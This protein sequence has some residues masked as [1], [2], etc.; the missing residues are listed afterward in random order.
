MKA[1]RRSL[2]FRLLAGFMSVMF[3]VWLLLG[4]MN[5]YEALTT[6]K[7]AVENDIK[8]VARQS[9]LVMQALATQPG[10]LKRLAAQLEHLENARTALVI[11]TMSPPLHLQVWKD[12]VPVFAS[13]RL[14]AELPQ[15]GAQLVSFSADGA[16]WLASVQADAASGVTVRAAREDPMVA[17]LEPPSIGYFTLPL[18]FSFPFLLLPVWVTIRVGL[19]PV[20]AMS[21]EIERRPVSDLTPLPDS[22][23]KELAPLVDAI[24]RL[25]GRLKERLEREREFL[26][27]AAHELKTPMAVIQVNADTLSEARDAQRVRDAREGL[28]IG[29]E[30]AAHAVHQLLAYARSAAHRDNPSVE[31][32]DLV[33]LLGERIAQYAPLALKRGIEMELQAPERCVLA[34]HRESVFLLID[35]LL[36]NAVKYSPQHGQV[37][38]RVQMQGKAVRLSIIDQGPGIAP[39]LRE[40]VFERF[41]RIPGQD[42][43]GS[44]LG[45]AIAERAA[46]HNHAQVRLD[47]GPDG[48]GLAAIVDFLPPPAA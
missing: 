4:L 39:A 6:G 18:M 22:S 38:V 7:K 37:L 32:L 45:L 33:E 17:L 28:R 34:L 16:K 19:R 29:I 25:M 5:A 36:D 26:A 15:P 24:N 47:Q 27:D 10:E 11:G 3:G 12:G 30:R 20:R 13:T 21:D 1:L 14:P 44:G 35:N 43:A 31:P 48:R 42:L 23:Y 8:T 9:L 46:A 40:K 41:F 2:F